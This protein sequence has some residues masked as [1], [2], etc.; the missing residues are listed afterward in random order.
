[1]GSLGQEETK[2]AVQEVKETLST[3]L[4]ATKQMVADAAL[5]AQ[6]ASRLELSSAR[7]K[8]ST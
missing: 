8:F 7:G 4:K 3:Q 1:M 5:T 6:N 2:K